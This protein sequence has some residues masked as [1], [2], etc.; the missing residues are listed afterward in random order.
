MIENAHLFLYHK[1]QMHNDFMKKTLSLVVI[2][3]LFMKFR[4]IFLNNQILF[5]WYSYL[6]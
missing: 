6:Q 5:K 2:R 1:L 4:T 3:L